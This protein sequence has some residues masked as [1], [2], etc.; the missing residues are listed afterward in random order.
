[1]KH[2]YIISA[3]CYA[4]LL[5][6]AISAQNLNPTVSVTRAY[7]GKLPEVHKP[8]QNMFV[9]DSLHK[10]DLDFDYSVFE[11]PYKGAYDFKPY[12]MEMRPQAEVYSGKK[13]Y[14]KAGAGYNL[15]PSVDAVWEPLSGNKFRL[16]VYA[17]HHSYIG[18][19]KLIGVNDKG[20]LSSSSGKVGGYDMYS[21]IGADGHAYMNNAAMTFD[22]GYIGIHT[23]DPVESS[24]VSADPAIGY[25]AARLS[26][27][28]NSENSAESYLYY[29]VAMK[30]RF[31]VQG[32]GKM[33]AA[34][35][36]DNAYMS[37]LNMNDIDFNVTLGPVFK[38]YNKVVADFGMG[39]TWYNGL[40]ISSVGNAYIAPKY[41]YAK[42]RWNLSLG[43]KIGFRMNSGEDFQGNDLNTNKGI[44]LYP[45]VYVGF[46]PIKD[47]MNLYFTAKGGEWRNPYYDLKESN[48]FF[49]PFVLGQMSNNSVEQYNL[50]LGFNGNIASRFRYDVKIGYR[51]FEAMP[52]GSIS[53]KSDMQGNV[54]IPNLAFVDGTAVY[55]DIILQWKSRNFALDSWFSINAS[56]M[57]DSEFIFFEPAR[58][59]GGI[60]AEY[61][62]EKRIY[63]GVS[64]EFASHRKDYHSVYGI[65]AW[66]DLGCHAEYVFSRK[67]SFWVRGE[68]LLNMNIQKAPL[69]T[70][71][72]I[73]FT[74][75]ICLNL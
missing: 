49:T 45:D 72:G 67:L 74:T 42:N 68:N 3:L 44:L 2:I 31:G 65:P 37:S 34:S 32:F 35:G 15:R 26:F 28:I 41:V 64:V 47:Y 12:T 70:T 66:T 24:P 71:G 46:T 39:M 29:D 11:N 13:F 61:N 16:G 48:H 20:N 55:S 25:N 38:R 27:R 73:G 54:Y 21:T 58:Y 14:L 19:Y 62:W 17:S 5:P 51:S 53:A 60:D 8:S 56:D 63:F 69:Y 6:G 18:N 7:E 43:L 10:F 57:N 9:P 4:M 33:P 1:M 40:F 30:Y 23:K 75:G 59:S 50:A 22:V 52:M 36:G